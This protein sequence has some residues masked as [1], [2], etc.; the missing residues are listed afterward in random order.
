MK[1]NGE[2]KELARRLREAADVAEEIAENEDEGRED[3]LIGKLMVKL[4]RLQEMQG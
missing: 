1:K 2:M 3:E 4:L